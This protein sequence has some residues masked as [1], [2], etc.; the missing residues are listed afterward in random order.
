MDAGVPFV[1]GNRQ[2]RQRGAMRRDSPRAQALLYSFT[3]TS[4][5]RHSSV[6]AYVPHYEPG[7]CYY[8]KTTLSATSMDISKEPDRVIGFRCF[9]KD[10]SRFRAL[11]TLNLDL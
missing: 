6:H 1:R 9:S 10:G 2:R 4:H 3:A 5:E 8:A 7:S 11:K